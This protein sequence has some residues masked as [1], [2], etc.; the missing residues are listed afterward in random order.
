L[1]VFC[2]IGIEVLELARISIGM[3]DEAPSLEAQ[4]VGATMPDQLWQGEST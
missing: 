2:F 3:V 4:A 1:R